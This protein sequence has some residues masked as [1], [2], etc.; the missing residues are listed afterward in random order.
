MKF[1]FCLLQNA[2]VVELDSSLEDRVRTQEDQKLPYV[3]V[4]GQVKAL[5]APVTSMN[6]W[7]TTGTIQKLCVKEHLIKRTTAGFWWYAE[8]SL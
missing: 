4:R 6:N 3:A 5:G 2:A 8:Y 7:K 1:Y